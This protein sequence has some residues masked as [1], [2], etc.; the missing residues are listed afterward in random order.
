MEWFQ[1]TLQTYPEI[2]VFL[3]LAIGYWVGAKTFKGFS[4]GAVTGTLLAAIVIGQLNIE[5]TGPL[6]SLFFLIFLFA[7]GYSIGPQFVRGL[8]KDGLPQVGYA[9]VQCLFSLAFPILITMV[10]GYDIGTTAG[11]FAGSQTIS[12][13]MGLATDAINRSGLSPDEVKH[14]L[15]YMPVAYAVA[16][17]FGTVGS[18][19]ILAQV[20]PK[21]MR[22][23]LE[24]ACKDYEKKNKADKTIN[25]EGTAWHE[26]ELRAYSLHNCAPGM[27]V[28]K[29]EGQFP[30]HHIFVEGV[31][32]GD[33]I[34]EPTS[35]MEIKDGDILAIGGDHHA[36]IKEVAEETTRFEEVEDLE[37][38]SQAVSGV[39]VLVTHKDVRGKS[40]A[41]LAASAGS[42]G[43]FIREIRRGAMGVTIPVLAT[44]TLHRGDVLTLF[45]LAK[46]VKR[47]AKD[48]GVIDEHT[49][50]TDVATLCVAMVIGCLIGA[51]VLKVWGLPLTLSTA[52]GALI[53]GI[54]FGWIRSIHPTFGYIPESTV[55]FMNSVG[56]N[57]FIAVIGISTGPDFIVGLKD[58]GVGIFLWG[59]AATSLPLICGAFVGK[60]IFKFH[61]A[62]LFGC[63]AGARTTTAALGMVNEQAKSNIPSL[64]YTITYAVG[65]TLLTMWGLV[66][67]LIMM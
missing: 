56:L 38:T 7:V 20:L 9:V 64:G 26:Y 57:V 43:V 48:L 17:V 16:Y 49:T 52:G 62:I 2:A 50:K 13:S 59:I 11:L 53:A 21:I 15:S 46:N 47:A 28:A 58:L 36:L 60:Y 10:A 5:V 63:C 18:A 32:R 4:L 31:R 65:N 40:L 39:D 1:T 22:I 25:T 54:I 27:T 37:L 42:H 41:Q 44:T 67:V 14:T 33:K 12:A 3:S 34:L 55:W 6:K 19:L 45:G 51:A 23:N 29:L 30:S 8:A 24:D 66:L 61:P 35:G